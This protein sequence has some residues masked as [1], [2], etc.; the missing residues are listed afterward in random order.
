MRQTPP[1]EIPSGIGHRQEQPNTGKEAHIRTNQERP[2]SPMRPGEETPIEGESDTEA[3]VTE[4]EKPTESGGTPR[5]DWK[6]HSETKPA[7]PARAPRHIDLEQIAYWV[8]WLQKSEECRK[9]WEKGWNEDQASK[10]ET[11]QFGQ[12]GPR[13]HYI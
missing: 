8:L 5:P 9:S 2:A 11:S 10:D 7:E 1:A 6:W 4:D 13:R 3:M 12:G